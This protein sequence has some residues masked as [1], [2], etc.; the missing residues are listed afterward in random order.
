VPSVHPSASDDVAVL[1]QRRLDHQPFVY[2][3]LDATY[4]H[5]RERG[6]VVSKAVVI[7]TRCRAD[8]HREALGVDLGTRRR[9]SSSADA[10]PQQHRFAQVHASRHDRPQHHPIG[11]RRLLKRPQRGAFR[12]MSRHVGVLRVRMRRAP[13]LQNCYTVIT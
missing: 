8:G 3:S 5:V 4:V 2:V 13:L 12:G 1:R 7:A 10:Q 9:R 6:Q 11:R